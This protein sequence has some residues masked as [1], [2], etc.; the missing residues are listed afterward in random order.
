[1]DESSLTTVTAILVRLVRVSKWDRQA[2]I[3]NELQRSI[4]GKRDIQHP[5]SHT[6]ASAN[7][8]H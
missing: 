8:I 1:M 3:K 6:A 2:I 5:S 4:Q 7:E